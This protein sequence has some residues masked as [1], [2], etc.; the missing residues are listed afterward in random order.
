MAQVFPFGA[1]RFNPQVAPS[2]LVLTQPY[3]KISPQ[4]QAEYYAMHAH[5]LIAVEKGR[6]HENDDAHNNVYTRA[7]AKVEEWIRDSVLLQDPAPAFY[8]YSQEFTVPGSNERRT[9]SGFIGAGQ[10]E[11]YS[12]GVVFRHEHTLSGPKAD[13]LELLRHTRL[14]TGQ[15]FMLYSD[16][17]RRVD[18]VLAGAEK[19]AAPATELTDEYGVIHRLWPITEPQRIHAIQQ[20]M[21]DHK[22]VIADGH[23]RYETALNYRNER[24]AQAGASAVPAASYE[25]AMMTFVNTRSE[26]LVI[27][28]THRVV[29][30]VHDFSWSAVRRYLEPWFSAEVFPFAN[31]SEQVQA[32]DKFL[33]RLKDTAAQRSIG[34]YPVAN[35]QRAFYLF[36]LRPGADLGQLLPNVPALQRELDVVLLHDG[37]LEPALGITLQTAT[38]EINLTY[39][40]EAAAAIAAVD[41]GRAQVS[42]LLNPVD[43]EKV[44]EI[45][46]AN[47][48]M[49]QKSTDFY[50]KLLSGITNYRLDL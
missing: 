38:K 22:L 3:D 29:A 44:V 26:G 28:A 6:T 34:A 32:R 13:R 11:D 43:V 45:A 15:L 12:A 10:L 18:T 47:E 21:A 37:I 49:P 1:L 23:H 31:D 33:A 9:R 8:A 20:A 41:S 42:F 25:R 40:R 7:A 5:N 24:R 35:G 46:T 17:Q 14:H 4:R 19:S 50:P 2:E 48:V 36:H 27:L 30:N 39:E 16:P